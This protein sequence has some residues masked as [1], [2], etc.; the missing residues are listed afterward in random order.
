MNEPNFFL[1]LSGKGGVGKSTVSSLV[2]CSLA[3]EKT[4]LID[5]DICGPSLAKCFGVKGKITKTADG[6]KPL[7]I[8][9][10]LDLLSFGNILNENDVVIWR[11]AKKMIFL[12]MLLKGAFLKNK[13]GFVYKN[14]VI[15]TPPGV[16]DEH[17]FLTQ[18]N[19]RFNTIFVT[20]SQNIALSDTIKTIEFAQKHD[21][22]ILGL[23]QNMSYMKCECCDENI[24]LYGKNGGELLAKEYEI[25]FLGEIEMSKELIN[26]TEQGEVVKF[27]KN[28]K[29]F[30][31][32][33]KSIK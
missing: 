28:S 9:E 7:E 12:E 22:N 26:A 27:Y 10:N 4:L 20:T 6:F 21:F 8:N 32:I 25:P 23:I 3:S 1:V 30:E 11:G 15:D 33:H 2:G 16:S 14:V 17:L 18:Q 24:Y 29:I 31:K 5:F 19:I 13:D